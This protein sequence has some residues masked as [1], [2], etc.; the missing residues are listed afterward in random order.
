MNEQ[1][2]SAT[3]G[4]TSKIERFHLGER[5]NNYDIVGQLDFGDA[6]Y[7]RILWNV[8]CQTILNNPRK[9][10]TYVAKTVNVEAI[11]EFLSD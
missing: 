8:E 7:T 11:A 4:Q 9:L 2:A 10:P 3:D 6:S 1:S 5:R